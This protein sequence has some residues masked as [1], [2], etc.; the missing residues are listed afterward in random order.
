MGQILLAK[1][2]RQ[3]QR[4]RNIQIMPGMKASSEAPRDGESHSQRN[5]TIFPKALNETT[6]VPAKK[7]PT[8]ED[9]EDTQNDK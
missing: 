3:S 2:I 9:V 6:I 5:Q 8:T 1:A 4:K 7:K